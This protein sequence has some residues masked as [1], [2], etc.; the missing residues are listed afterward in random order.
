[1]KLNSLNPF[2]DLW[3]KLVLATVSA[4]VLV[5]CGSG[6]KVVDPLNVKS[7]A[8]L[9]DGTVDVAQGVK[10]TRADPIF[11][12]WPEYLATGYGLEAADSDFLGAVDATVS[13][14]GNSLE[15]QVDAFINGSKVTKSD[16]QL[17]IVSAGMTDIQTLA[18]QVGS[19]SL[20]EADALTKV[21]K[22]AS[23]YMTHIKKLLSAGASRVAVTVPYNLGETQW[24]KDN[25]VEAVASK[26][27]QAYRSAVRSQIN[28]LP[29][30]FRDGSVLYLQVP[31][32]V[33]GYVVGNSDG[34][35]KGYVALCKPPA[36]K[37]VTQCNDTTLVADTAEEQADYP[38]ADDRFLAPYAHSALANFVRNRI[39]VTWR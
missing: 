1:M 35:D 18:T 15:A 31:E 9:G 5:S 29:A 19:S 12:T 8:V 24:A 20:T 22:L 26:L 4:V 11:K 21:N 7:I 28:D 36:D 23:E 6:G 38:F 30:A 39:D 16:G 34:F 27:S 33:R 3:S 37:D 14:A 2:S 32:E 17:F 25:S 10:D 13:G